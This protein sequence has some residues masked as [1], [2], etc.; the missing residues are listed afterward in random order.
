LPEAWFFPKQTLSAAATGWGPS[1][2]LP[3]ASAFPFASIRV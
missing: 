3:V 1:A 2:G